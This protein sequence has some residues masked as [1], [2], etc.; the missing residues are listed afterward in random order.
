MT[1]VQDVQQVTS[2]TEGKSCLKKH[3]EAN[4]PTGF[5]LVEYNQKYGGWA[6]T[7]YFTQLNEQNINPVGWAVEE[8]VKDFISWADDGWFDGDISSDYL[9]EPEHEWVGIELIKVQPES[10]QPKPE[11]AKEYHPIPVIKS[12]EI[13]NQYDIGINDLAPVKR[14][15][16]LLGYI[17]VVRKGAQTYE[18]LKGDIPE[19]LELLNREYLTIMHSYTLPDAYA[20]AINTLTDLIDE[21][22]LF[23]RGYTG[24]LGERICLARDMLQQAYMEMPAAVL[25]DDM[26]HTF[27]C[28]PRHDDL[29][30]KLSRQKRLENLVALFNAMQAELFTLWASQQ[31]PLVYID[32][33]TAL[34][35]GLTLMETIKIPTSFGVKEGKLCAQ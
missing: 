17:R 19:T 35:N 1:A 13:R 2:V 16:E 14:K 27:V 3:I 5:E 30:G 18:L 32:N 4:A 7:Q 31:L 29:T 11:P 15:L 20:E 23:A 28:Q 10:P 33:V 25:P 21:V 12:K 6:Q 34:N 8:L 22:R 9:P 24:E 26:Q